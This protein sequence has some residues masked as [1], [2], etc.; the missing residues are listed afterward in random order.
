MKN[1]LLHF[2]DLRVN[3]TILQSMTKREA[4]L[5]SEE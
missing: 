2:P 5:D 3:Y 4:Y 1:S